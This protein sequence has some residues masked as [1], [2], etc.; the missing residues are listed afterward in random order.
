MLEVNGDMGWD[1]RLC[2]ACGIPI[3]RITGKIFSIG[4]LSSDL[5]DLLQE[6]EFEINKLKKSESGRIQIQC[7]GYMHIARRTLSKAKI[8]NFG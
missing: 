2:G 4:E 3:N 7:Q 8:G 1:G 6:C 5:F